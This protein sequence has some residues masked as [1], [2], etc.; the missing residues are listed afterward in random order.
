MN[1]FLAIICAAIISMTALTQPSQAQQISPQVMTHARTVA[2][3]CV[4]QWRTA[5]CIQAMGKS[6]KDLVIN[7]AS[8]LNAKGAKAALDILKQGCA[9]ATV[10]EKNNMPSKAFASAYNE[11]SNTIYDLSSRTNTLPDQSHYQLLVAGA[12]CMDGDSRCGQFEAQ[13]KNWIK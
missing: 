1:R 3:S 7:Y 12:L 9:A 13:M 6:N 10:A 5:S 11:C 8:A 2:V 4:G